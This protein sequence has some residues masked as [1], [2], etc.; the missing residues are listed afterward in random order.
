MKILLCDG[1]MGELECLER[2]VAR[3]SA[4]QVLCAGGLEEAR[5]VI[6]RE[7]PDIVLC[8]S[9]L[10]DGS[11]FDLLRES[12][13]GRRFVFAFVTRN[14]RFEDVRE[15]LRLGA[16]DW[17]TKP[18]GN[19]V[20]HKALHR[21]VE[22]A[23]L[24]LR[25][26][27]GSAIVLNNTLRCIWEGS[28]GYE[29]ATVAASLRREHS[30]LDPDSRW[31]A[32][33]VTADIVD[34][35]SHGWERELL[36]YGLKVLAQEAI[37]RRTDAAQILTNS[38]ERFE[39]LVLFIRAEDVSESEL[40]S[41]CAR[42]VSLC[43]EQ[44]E[45]LP[46]CVIG[47]AAPLYRLG[48]AA[49]EMSKTGYESRMLQKRVLLCRELGEQ[50]QDT[51]VY[52]DPGVISDCIRRQNRDEYLQYITSATRKIISSSSNINQQ[53]FSLHDEL[54]R[55]FTEYAAHRGVSAGALM[56]DSQIR[57]LNSNAERSEYDM[58]EFASAIFDRVAGLVLQKPGAAGVIGDIK[59]YIRLH[60][61]E[62]ITR[63]QLAEYAHLSPGYLS[64][65]FRRDTGVN[66]TQYINRLRIQE[67][68]KLLLSTD[69]PIDDI[70]ARVGF[71]SQSYFSSVFR[72]Q[73]GSSPQSWRA[74]MRGK[75]SER[76]RVQ[77]KTI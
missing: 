9:E 12:G 72:K 35:Q 3:E 14:R 65:R 39:F 51:S 63:E 53:I 17:I 13:R 37:A 56:A 7:S 57:E 21:L 77:H 62:E 40:V 6:A 50:T 44:F 61:S 15:A 41:R 22:Q 11:G 71:E 31:R 30:E 4:G 76:G 18:V 58:L 38:H 67:A 36:R 27:E 47:D 60:L 55:I 8:E 66:I 46:L 20:L 16:A 25:V 48:S 10:P 69:F 24:A 68:Q 75:F 32:L 45:V 33:A 73:C 54:L 52:Y 2:A 34:A 28:Y 23:H 42:Y 29:R 1:D 5:L 70:A 19:D 74:N 59:R 49:L 26:A 43:R 64:K